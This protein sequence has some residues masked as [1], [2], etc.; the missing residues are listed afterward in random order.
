M[1]EGFEVRRA[2]R[3]REGKKGS[4]DEQI[5][6]SCVREFWS[7]LKRWVSWN[8]FRDRV[9]SKSTPVAYSAF[10][11]DQLC[12]QITF[13]Y[14]LTDACELWKISSEWKD[15]K[16]IDSNPLSNDTFTG[17]LITL[18]RQICLTSPNAPPQHKAKIILRRCC[19]NIITH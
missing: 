19:W 1:F 18:E 2:E 6:W 13:G 7:L 9:S 11:W 12:H 16:E 3:E 10:V 14:R 15:N 5:L 4:Q 8:N 17:G